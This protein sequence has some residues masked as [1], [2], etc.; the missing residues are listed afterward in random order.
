[1]DSAD[2]F[3]TLSLL[4]VLC[5]WTQEMINQLNLDGLFTANGNSLSEKLYQSRLSSS[6]GQRSFILSVFP[7]SFIS[8]NQAQ[9]TRY[10][11][12][13][14]ERDRI[15]LLLISS[16]RITE[17]ILPVPYSVRSSDCNSTLFKRHM[18]TRWQASH[19]HLQ[20]SKQPR[21]G[22]SAKLNLGFGP[23]KG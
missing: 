21:M 12:G 11:A 9:S 5:T 22:R 15:L 18:G 20:P 8:C 3:R 7:R 19:R 17:Q 2:R 16:Q 10:E 14:G 4:T 6:P 13:S 23:C 1:M